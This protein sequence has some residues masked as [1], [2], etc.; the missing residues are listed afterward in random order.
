MCGRS[1][2]RR[3]AGSARG[4]ARCG[5]LAATAGRTTPG[6]SCGFDAPA[7]GRSA[8]PT[9]PVLVRHLLWAR[10]R[11]PSADAAA[12]RRSRPAG[13]LPARRARSRHATWCCSREAPAPGS[14]TATRRDSPPCIPH[15][16]ADVGPSPAETLAEAPFGKLLFS[17]GPGRC[18]SCT[19]SA[20][21]TFVRAHAA[22]AGQVG[23]G[24]GAAPC[25][26]GSIAGQVASGTAR[27]IYRLRGRG[28]GL[29]GV[30]ADGERRRSTVPGLR[31]PAARQPALAHRQ[32]QPQ[33]ARS[34]PG[35]AQH[36]RLRPGPRAVR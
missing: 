26:R 19:W 36:V 21:A 25:G 12:V 1:R 4:A 17:S 28:R 31:A 18:P 11:H 33:H 13:R 29:S 24:R 8:V 35:G 23:R 10:A 22:A 27:R 6:E 2:G 7:G 16:Y 34:T 3:A 5:P 14:T 9:E 15:V 20:R 32:Q 30:A